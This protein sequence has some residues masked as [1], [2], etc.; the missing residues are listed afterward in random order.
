MQEPLAELLASAPV[1]AQPFPGT[2]YPLPIQQALY[3]RMP[4]TGWLAAQAGAAETVVGALEPALALAEAVESA[5]GD[6]LSYFLSDARTRSLVFTGAKWRAGWVLLVG[7]GVTEGL[8]R[9]VIDREFL[10]FCADPP[11][12]LSARSIPIPRRPTGAVYFLQLAVRYGLIYGRIKPGDGHELGHFLESD[13][14]GVVVARAPLTPLESF[15]VLGLMKLGLPA[16]VPSGFPYSEGCQ[17]VADEPGD[18]LRALSSFPNLR[19]KEVDGRVIRLPDYADPA[20]VAERFE[21]TRKLG[22]TSSFLFLHQDP[23]T[24]DGD[25]VVGQEPIQGDL[26]VVVT[27]ANSLATDSVC[28]FLEDKARAAF[29][30]LKGVRARADEEVGQALDV[31]YSADSTATPEHLAETIRRS[32]Q[33]HYPRLGPVAVRLTF[34]SDELGFASRSQIT[35]WVVE[36]RLSG[37]GRQ[38]VV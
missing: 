33:F 37:G 14:P 26:G 11:A 21:P 12:D 38:S 13:V 23:L 5:A 15:L 18:V 34:D 20:N 19:V 10:A 32:L 28:E 29:G 2:E 6:R 8:V 1:A 27:V 16:V 30:L 7:G 17:V 3:G 35:A 4:E 24:I 22:G 9:S 31:E 25:V 36:K